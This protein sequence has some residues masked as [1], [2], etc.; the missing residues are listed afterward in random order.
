MGDEV[1]AIV[2]V[3]SV[4]S[5]T[6]PLPPP[7]PP[8]AEMNPMISGCKENLF[9]VATTL[10]DFGAMDAT[11]LIAFA[12]EDRNP[13]GEAVERQTG[14]RIEEGEEDEEESTIERQR[15]VGSWETVPPN[16]RR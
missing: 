10:L 5:A 12:R 6:I 15:K 16:G 9:K 4:T 1:V 3:T 11:T 14:G 2:V 7:P 13:K 8:T